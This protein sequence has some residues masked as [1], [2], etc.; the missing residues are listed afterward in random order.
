M[1]GCGRDCD[2]D[3]CRHGS[4]H[5]DAFGE[6]FIHVIMEDFFASCP[7]NPDSQQETI[8]TSHPIQRARVAE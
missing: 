5:D 6:D 2:E 1:I 7:P 8:Y 4:S 3:C